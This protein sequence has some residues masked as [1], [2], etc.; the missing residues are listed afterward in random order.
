MIDITAS[1]LS[2]ALMLW[3]ALDIRFNTAWAKIVATVFFSVVLYMAG[4]LSF[5]GWQGITP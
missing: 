5:I 3:A 1:I 2:L 4:R